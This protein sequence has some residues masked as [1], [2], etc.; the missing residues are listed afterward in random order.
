MKILFHSLTLLSVLCFMSG[1]QKKSPKT[2]G[3]SSPSFWYLL[4]G[5]YT[6]TGFTYQGADSGIY[7]L[8]MN[9]STGEL[10]LVNSSP[11]IENPSFLVFDS[12]RSQVFSVNENENGSI[13]SFILDTISMT[14]RFL[15]TI[16]S[17]GKYP[18]Y[19]SLDASGKFVLTANYGSG[20][21]A[22]FPIHSDGKVGK[23]TSIHQHMG[24][25]PIADRQEGPHAHMILP[26]PDGKFIYSTDL[27]TDELYVY[28]LDTEK[29]SLIASG[30]TI[31]T[32]SGA[33]PRH[34][35]FHNVKPWGY[36]VNELNG[37]IESYLYDE[38]SGNLNRFQIVSTR[39]QNDDRFAGC[40]DI[41]IH[42]SGLFLYATN[43]GDIN[44]IVL[45]EIDQHTGKL[46][47][48]ANYSSG[49]KTPRNFS[50]SPDGKF[51]LCAHQNTN[52]IV[53]FRIEQA[54]GK[55]S[56]TEETISIPAPVCLRFIPI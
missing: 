33:G 23:A 41:H 2:A 43:R 11:A 12:I 52:N 4:T 51:L 35:A 7:I 25:G 19:I 45:F 1:C 49:G 55:L 38:K 27:G 3:S 54:T 21:V 50:I 15:N 26:S 48:R 9:T 39:L 42:P 30:F 34:I 36:V 20:N 18:C 14:L 5:T 13:S 16:S 53:V 46:S 31:K 37:T 17:E 44:E 56:P 24:N 32:S 22:A 28:T 10:S 47:H 29:G 6:G 8:R 40:A